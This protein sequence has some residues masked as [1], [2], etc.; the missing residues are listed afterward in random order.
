[1]ILLKTVGGDLV[2]ED[3]LGND[4][5]LDGVL[6]CRFDVVVDWSFLQ[7]FV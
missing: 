7:S 1:M 5:D 4:F 2:L 6:V 3:V